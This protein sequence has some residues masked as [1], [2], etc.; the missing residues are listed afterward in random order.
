MYLS[1]LQNLRFRSKFALVAGLFLMIGL[2]GYVIFSQQQQDLRS[3]ASTD[4]NG[5]YPG[6]LVGDYYRVAGTVLGNIIGNYNQVSNGVQGGIYGSSNSIVGNIGGCINGNN[7]R[8]SGSVTGAVIGTNNIV[9]GTKGTGDCP[10]PGSSTPVPTLSLLSPTT[11]PPTPTPTPVP[12]RPTSTPT[13][14]P[15]P[16]TPTSTPIPT[17]LPSPTASLPGNTSIGLT[18]FLHGIGKGGDSVNP[19]GGGNPRPLHPQRNIKIEVLNSQ[20][21]VVLTKDGFINLNNTNGNFTGSIDMGSTL[22]TGEYSVKI[23]SNQFL[24]RLLPGIQNITVGQT[25]QLPSVALVNGDIDGN[26]SINILDYN[27]LMGCF[28]DLLP[29]ISCPPANKLLSDIDDDGNVNQFDYN[30]FLRELT[31]VLGQ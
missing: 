3:R 29:A 16:P 17:L 5:N 31:N 22:K 14:T 28:S 13:P 30:L 11:L 25:N 8:I 2:F 10:L 12:L 19:N 20:N 9:T 15:I 26:N 4:I 6:D 18:A 24:R 7:N 27:I 21:Q 1:R 23:K